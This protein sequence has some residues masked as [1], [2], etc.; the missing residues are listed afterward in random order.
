[1]KK[2]L[3]MILSLC[4]LCGA[5]LAELRAAGRVGAD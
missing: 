3:A 5:A 1:M 2:L 4:L